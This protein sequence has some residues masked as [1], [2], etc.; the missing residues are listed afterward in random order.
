MCEFVLLTDGTLV[1]NTSNVFLSFEDAQL[2]NVTV[3]SPEGEPLEWV[4]KAR[5]GDRNAAD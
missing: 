1:A 3:F 2:V 5:M 4:S